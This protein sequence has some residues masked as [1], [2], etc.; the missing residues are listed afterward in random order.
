[1]ASLR[2]NMGSHWVK[3]YMIGFPWI[4]LGDNIIDTLILIAALLIIAIELNLQKCNGSITILPGNRMISYLFSFL[5]PTYPPLHFY[6]ITPIQ[7]TIQGKTCTYLILTYKIG[8]EILLFYNL[9]WFTLVTTLIKY[10]PKTFY[11]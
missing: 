5:P 1:M 11:C 3:G 4:C 8:W 10:Y 2:P 6:C 9:H 7:M